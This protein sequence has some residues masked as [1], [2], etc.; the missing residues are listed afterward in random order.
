M[1][2]VTIWKLI[3]VL[4]SFCLVGNSL[5]EEVPP[6]DVFI[7]LD[8]SSTV[9][10]GGQD[11]PSRK[12]PEMLM[13]LFQ[14]KNPFDEQLPYLTDQDQVFLYSFGEDVKPIQENIGG[15]EQ[16]NIE[17]ELT[18]FAESKES[19][20]T[21][22]DRLFS[23][24]YTNP[25]IYGAADG[26]MKMVLIASDFIHDPRNS[27][28]D[29]CAAADRFIAGGRGWG[30]SNLEQLVEGNK[31]RLALKQ[32][33]VVLAFIYISPEK[34]P[35]TKTSKNKETNELKTVA[36]PYGKC[37]NRLFP[38]RPTI[39]TIEKK[40]I[41]AVLEYASL[42][43]DIDSFAGKVAESFNR[44]MLPPLKVESATGQPNGRGGYNIQ[45][46]LYNRGK[47]GNTVRSIEL[48]DSLDGDRIMP[49]LIDESRGPIEP[50]GRVTRTYL[51]NPEHV[52]RISAAKQ[53]YVSVHDQSRTAGGDKRYQVSVRDVGEL[54]VQKVEL[55]AQTGGGDHLLIVETKNGGKQEKK[56][57]S[58]LI[59]KEAVG[60]G[61]PE[62]VLKVNTTPLTGG[63][64]RPL[65][66]PIGNDVYRMLIDTVWVA[67]AY[68]ADS[69]TAR[70]E[71]KVTRVPGVIV[72][73]AA[74]WSEIVPG[75]YQL[76]VTVANRSN[77]LGT[78]KE[79]KIYDENGVTKDS[80]KVHKTLIDAA[81]KAQD[82]ACA[83]PFDA[84]NK[85]FIFDRKQNQ[86]Q[87][88]DE[89][90][91]S[92]RAKFPIDSPPRTNIAVDEQSVRVTSPQEKTGKL[93]L[94]FKARNTDNIYNSII[95]IEMANE[96]EKTWY[97]IKIKDGNVPQ[98]WVFDT[99]NFENVNIDLPEGFDR[100][101]KV[102]RPLRMRVYDLGG[103][104]E[105]SVQGFASK[106]F[107]INAESVRWATDRRLL[108]LIIT[109][110]AEYAQTPSKIEFSSTNDGGGE[111]VDIAKEVEIFSQKESRKFDL[112]VADPRLNAILADDMWL[113]VWSEAAV[114]GL[115]DKCDGVWYG[116]GAPKIEGNIDVVADGDAKPLALDVKKKKLHVIA[117]NQDV[118]P[119]K[120]DKVVV[121]AGDREDAKPISIP[122]AENTIL[123]GGGSERL[124]LNLDDVMV[125][126]LSTVDAIQ[127]ALVRVD[128]A[129]PSAAKQEYSALNLGSVSAEIQGTSY[130]QRFQSNGNVSL[131][132]VDVKF[133]K[134][135][136]EKILLNDL[137]IEFSKDGKKIGRRHKIDRSIVIDSGVKSE[138]FLVNTTLNSIDLNGAVVDILNKDKKFK[139]FPEKRVSTVLFDASIVVSG[140]LVA[141]LF[142]VGLHAWKD[143]RVR[144]KLA[145]GDGDCGSES[146]DFVMWVLSNGKS[147]ISK[148]KAGTVLGATAG[149]AYLPFSG[150][151]MELVWWLSSILTALTFLGLAFV[152]AHHAQKE[153]SILL[154]GGVLSAGRMSG[155]RMANGG[156]PWRAVSSEMSRLFP[157]GGWLKHIGT[158]AVAR[159]IVYVVIVLA[160][161]LMMVPIHNFWF[162][163]VHSLFG[164]VGVN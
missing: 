117:T 158:V 22:L 135:Y 111:L 6:K 91:T 59:F 29:L 124:V 28:T 4:L 44:F 128:V 3:G 121:K 63:E 159:N 47:V 81:T 36:F 43:R 97:K 21:D 51:V 76:K 61:P 48:F 45:L 39:T 140:I 154:Y 153:I 157:H 134:N 40:E 65:S 35:E 132:R 32:L 86:L 95:K 102:D 66:V 160:V 143:R 34:M 145:C 107:T 148:I 77:S 151:N 93:S 56:P 25:Y 126:E 7:Y 38:L 20:K 104:Q 130:A 2:N 13:K 15:K 129:N 114:K 110:S 133:L 146:G 112:S 19:S 141:I 106:P 125:R 164:S 155:T 116:V 79:I 98:E 161:I 55:E 109:N 74:R 11:S 105:Y 123:T 71:A 27:S 108:S 149:Q 85:R 88:F 100:L 68:D 113:C 119:V 8:R 92:D 142:V 16:K 69:V 64:T 33:P 96:V 58:V 101:I 23:A 89:S 120:I 37:F 46:S 163:T 136:P 122:V 26:R 31:S 87:V 50:N 90:G 152:V 139:Q 60:D 99:N 24:I 162:S 5:A 14:S 72:P 103:M 57:H 67:V 54:E 9:L 115:K 12:I 73:I 49:S 131:V 83:E 137:S 147:Q 53:L 75:R 30:T 156:E 138:S 150:W 17:K 62:R 10:G 78:I 144:R 118:Y 42:S 52:E 94:E 1:N 70:K 41:G 84:L 80:C 127:N 82:V 18:Q